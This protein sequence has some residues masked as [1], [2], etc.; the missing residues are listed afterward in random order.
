MVVVLFL[1]LH[2]QSFLFDAKHANNSA[3]VF[4]KNQP[5]NKCQFCFHCLLSALMPLA[6]EIQKSAT[7]QRPGDIIR[8]KEQP[9]NFEIH[10]T[11]FPGLWV[12]KS[13]VFL[14]DLSPLLCFYF[15]SPL[16]AP[17]RPTDILRSKL[18]C[19]PFIDYARFSVL[20][21]LEGT[22]TSVS[23]SHLGE[24]EITSQ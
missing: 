1:L 8:D 23:T 20:V 6:I 4:Y 17:Q 22:D 2:V 15:N 9:Q 10:I 14:L 3:N 5:N 12:G 13:F 24:E 7:D 11:C 21:T 18:N 16:S 19:V